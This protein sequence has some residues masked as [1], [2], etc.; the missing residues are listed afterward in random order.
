MSQVLSLIKD[1]PF[2]FVIPTA[3]K[4]FKSKI[5]K[6]DKALLLVLNKGYVEADDIETCYYVSTFLESHKSSLF[7]LCG[8]IEKI[9][10]SKS[11]KIVYR[12]RVY[13]KSL[14]TLLKVLRELNSSVIIDKNFKITT[15]TLLHCVSDLPYLER[16]AKRLKLDVDT[17][18]TCVCKILIYEACNKLDML[19]KIN[20]T[21]EVYNIPTTESG[22]L[23]RAPM[24]CGSYSVISH[25][26]SVFRVEDTSNKKLYSTSVRESLGVLSYGYTDRNVRK[27]KKRGVFYIEGKDK[28]GTS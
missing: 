21:D 6:K 5:A 19:D 28:R 8:N 17:W 11:E 7:V 2:K 27:D 10:L 1:K 14:A 25:T 9:K 13:F 22:F 20:L 16:Y 18:L 26:S 23:D 3:G 12:Q 24:L 15:N 4:C